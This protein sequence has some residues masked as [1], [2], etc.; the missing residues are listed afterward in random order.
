MGAPCGLTP[1]CASRLFSPPSHPSLRTCKQVARKRCWGPGGGFARSKCGGSFGGVGAA[2]VWRHRHDLQAQHRC[3]TTPANLDSPAL[4]HRP[5]ACTSIRPPSV[6][7]SPA[8]QQERTAPRPPCAVGICKRRCAPLSPISFVIFWRQ[9]RGLLEGKPRALRQLCL[10]I[11]V[12][13]ETG[14]RVRCFG[15]P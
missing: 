3:W 7:W 13:R 1:R 6:R 11:D 2:S 5:N 10:A 15:G 4:P 14:L 8:L 12:A 9:A